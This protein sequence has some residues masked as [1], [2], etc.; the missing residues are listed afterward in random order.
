MDL[1]T[2]IDHGDPRAVA[3]QI[4]RSFGGGILAAHDDDVVIEIRMRFAIVMEDLGQVLTRNADLVGQIV[5]AGRDNDLPGAIIKDV[6]L[7]ISSHHVKIAIFA[8][9]GFDPLVLTNLQI[10]ML[11][12]AA[13]IFER[14]QAGRL[15][16]RTGE[17][18]VADFEQL[19]RREKRHVRRIVKDRIDQAAFVE[20]ECL[21]S[22]FLGFDCAGESR[23]A[24][25][26]NEDVSL[27]VALRDGLGAREGLGD[28][29]NRQVL[30][31]GFGLKS[32]H[33]SIGWSLGVLQFNAGP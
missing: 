1:G 24:G 21:E 22:G 6:P 15:H 26:Y 5:I 30:R 10:V 16:Q 17:W 9:D 33:S 32:N 25:P 3:P 2:S 18:D 31:L 20:D 28:E 14:L 13:I 23:R 4:E 19:R 12:C 27:V 7:P 11:G 8:V 29:F